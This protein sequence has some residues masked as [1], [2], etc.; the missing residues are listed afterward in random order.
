[1]G[2]G[3]LVRLGMGHCFVRL[4]K[5]DKASVWVPILSLALSTVVELPK[6]DKAR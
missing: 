1:M 6:Q 5:L 2:T 4:N 3:T